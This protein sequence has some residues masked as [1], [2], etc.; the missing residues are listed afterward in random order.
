MAM[1]V[2]YEKA[3]HTQFSYKEKKWN[4]P[5]KKEKNPHRPMPEEQDGIP[6]H[7]FD[8]SSN[9][10]HDGH[11]KTGGSYVG[12]FSL[13]FYERFMLRMRIFSDLHVCPH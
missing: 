8:E 3:Q 7:C 2:R 6:Q 9:K 1:D 12:L 11:A 10:S 5:S 4:Q 13:S